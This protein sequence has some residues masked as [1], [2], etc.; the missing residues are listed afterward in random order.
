M[1][2]YFLKTVSLL[3]YMFR[4]HL[5]IIRCAPNKEFIYATGC[6]DTVLLIIKASN[7]M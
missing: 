7:L 2:Q 6:S 5:I 1:Q 4:L 3:H